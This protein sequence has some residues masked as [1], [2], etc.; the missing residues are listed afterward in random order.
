MFIAA[1]M[2]VGFDVRMLRVRLILLNRW[3]PSCAARFHCSPIASG[4]FEPMT[5]SPSAYIPGA[6]VQY[7]GATNT[8]GSR[9]RASIRRGVGADNVWR[10][11]VP[12]A[13]GPDAAASAVVD[14]FNA[15]MG[16][17]WRVSGAALSLDGGNLYA[18][19]LAAT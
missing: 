8:R 11:S 15:A 4:L 18:Y 14:A 2:P 17:D 5:H 1:S 13:D 6:V 12:Y 19:P 7:V 9:W 16:A 10:A 3:L